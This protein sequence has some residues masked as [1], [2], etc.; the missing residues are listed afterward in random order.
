MTLYVYA[1]SS[2]VPVCV[3]MWADNSSPIG[4]LRMELQELAAPLPR[5]GSQSR[6]CALLWRARWNE[7]VCIYLFLFLSSI[8]FLSPL[9]FL[10]PVSLCLPCSLVCSYGRSIF[11]TCGFAFHFLVHLTPSPCP[12]HLP[13]TPP[14]VCIQPSFRPLFIKHP[15]LLIHFPLA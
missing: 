3:H 5:M 2:T 11:T 13:S 7:W 1:F 9:I 10:F 6:D 4:I 14:P 8:H 12:T 15:S